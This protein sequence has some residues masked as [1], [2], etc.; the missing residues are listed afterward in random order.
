MEN[1]FFSFVEQTSYWMSKF[2][3][4]GVNE[5]FLISVHQEEFISSVTSLWQKLVCD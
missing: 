3:V 2:L 4:S 1:I 5:M